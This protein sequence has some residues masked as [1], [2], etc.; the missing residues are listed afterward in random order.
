RTALDRLFDEAYRADVSISTD[1]GSV[2]YAHS[3]ILGIASPVFK[4]ILSQQPGK[5]LRKELRINGVPPEAVRIFIRFLYSSSSSFQDCDRE[6][7]NECLVPLLVL[8]H[9]Y[10]IPHLKRL[11]ERR[12]E[13]DE[14]RFITTAN[15]IDVFQ[16]AL[17]CDAPRLALICHRFIVR[18]LKAVS[19]SEGWRDMRESHPVL[20]KEILASVAAEESA[21]RERTRKAKERK[22][23]ELLY[24]AMEAL[25]VICSRD[26]DE[27]QHHH[28]IVGGGGGA[29]EGLAALIRHL[30][31]CKTRGG[32]VHC[33]RMW[34]ILELHSFMCGRKGGEE[35]EGGCCR[36][37]LCRN[38]REK[39][40]RRKKEDMMRWRILVQKTV[41]SK[42]IT[43]APFFSLQ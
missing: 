40:R 4:A 32:C 30:E 14:E 39:R 34:Q 9:A 12:M 3:N 6:T 1:G 21:K 22:V 25:V 18:N 10:A 11:C 16:L 8:S 17:L 20:E 24:E 41:R 29:R 36:V 2:L 26:G 7:L 5:R 15:A 27:K 43:G 37:P 19:G 35:E 23:Y 31:G 13:E 38:F 42:S 28:H 33:R